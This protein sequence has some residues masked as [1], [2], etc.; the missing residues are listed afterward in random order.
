MGRSTED[1]KLEKIH[2]V[3]AKVVKK[4]VTVVV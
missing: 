3:T 1:R 2:E 4:G